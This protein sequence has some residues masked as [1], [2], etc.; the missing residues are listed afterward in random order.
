MREGEGMEKWVW[1]ERRE[2]KRE[3]LRGVERREGGTEEK[4]GEVG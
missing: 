2:S 4:G 1:S 3:K